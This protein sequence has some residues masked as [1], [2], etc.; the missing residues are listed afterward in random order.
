ME[1]LLN[2]AEALINDGQFNEAVELLCRQGV[3]DDTR[4]F[5]LIALAHHKKDLARGDVYTAAVFAA[6]AINSGSSKSRSADV[7]APSHPAG[8]GI[9]EA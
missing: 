6:R 8:P 3:P 2:E 1:Q 4:V 5:E 9:R 7:A